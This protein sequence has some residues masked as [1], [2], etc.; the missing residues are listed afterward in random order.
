M[1]GRNASLHRSDPRAPDLTVARY[2]DEK[3]RRIIEKYGPG[4]RIH[5]HSGIHARSVP[6]DAPLDEVRAA[7]VAAQEELVE[8][9][10]RRVPAQS[11]LDVGCGLGGAA[12]IFAKHAR[13][14]AITIVPSHVEYVRALGIDAELRDAH[15]LVGLAQHDAAVAIES[16]CYF[17]R[18]RWF[19][20][21]RRVLPIGACV[22]VVDCFVGS[23]RIAAR[24]DEY[25]K[26]NIGTL[27]SYDDAARDFRRV[28]THD[29]GPDTL[30]FCDA[31]HP[32]VPARRTQ[33][34]PRAPHALDERA[35]VAARVDR[36]RRD[37]LSVRHLP[38]RALVAENFG[39]G[40]RVDTLRR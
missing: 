36:A 35:H 21:L 7:L 30:D 23:P 18:A 20:E 24:F 25:W 32:L 12:L 13:V 6:N 31:Q 3:S 29:Y 1:P 8:E 10:S 22:H 27:E 2:Y 39:R 17:D 34:R 26:T 14:T 11:I 15:D 5:F 9:V 4:P 40:A 37:P 28:H 38:P 19:S 16:S 33:R